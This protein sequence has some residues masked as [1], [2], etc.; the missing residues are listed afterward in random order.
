MTPQPSMTEKAPPEIFDA[1]RIQSLRLRRFYAYWDS[2][3]GAA[4][5]PLRKDIDPLEIPYALGFILIAE[6][7]PEP[8]GFRI[9]LMGDEIVERFAI[10]M[11]G[12]GLTDYPEP[13]Y[14][15]LVRRTFESVLD[16]RR[17]VL[18]QRE[19]VVGTR[20][21]RYEGLSLPLTSNGGEINTVVSCLDFA[22]R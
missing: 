1:Q 14:R 8:E 11:T 18:V 4:G 22:D 17:P 2:K 20:R 13:V 21:H 5:C 7:V 6:A 9:R 19:L 10:D 12:R 3:R 16:H 15:D